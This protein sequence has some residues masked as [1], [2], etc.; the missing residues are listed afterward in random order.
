MEIFSTKRGSDELLHVTI[1]FQELRKSPANR[2]RRGKAIV[3][4]DYVGTILEAP[5]D[6]HYTKV[7]LQDIR[8]G[9]HGAQRILSGL[10]DAREGRTS[11]TIYGLTL[12]SQLKLL[13]DPIPNTWKDFD[14]YTET[15]L[16]AALNIPVT[17]L[18]GWLPPRL[19]KVVRKFETR[20]DRLKFQVQWDGTEIRKPIVFS[21]DQRAFIRTLNFNGKHVSARGYFYVQHGQVKPI[22]LQGLLVRIR[23]SSV[24]GYD[25]TFWEFS[26]SEY[27]L[28]Q[29]WVSCE[30][31]ADDRLEEAMNI[32]RRTLR[33][34][35]PSY[36]ELRAAIHDELR[37]VCSE[38]RRR[39][40]EA[41]SAE[42]KKETASS[43]RRAISH[44]ATEAG[45]RRSTRKKIATAW[46]AALKRNH[47][48]LKKYTL[49]EI[50]EVVIEVATQVLGAA[51]RARFIEAI[52]ERFSR[53]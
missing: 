39:I 46:R 4:A 50:Y 8:R 43:T 13:K 30:I 14:S 19:R 42:R 3:K 2:R 1:D 9:A 21:P 51:E 29:K 22:E 17:Y 15:V 32:D 49:G 44:A 6:A 52:T 48:L 12:H 40:Y 27:S 24:G 38:A 5:R 10:M 36:V 26:Q 47:P 25:Q 31:W 53:G 20:I 18:D 11:E 37:R 33:I 45:L 28:I 7:F 16:Q 23:E 34:T 35:H 41:G